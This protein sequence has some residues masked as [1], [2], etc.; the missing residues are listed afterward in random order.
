MAQQQIVHTE[1]KR[2]DLFSLTGRFDSS[3]AHE[4]SDAFEQAMRRGRF[5]FV[6]DLSKAEYI[7]SG[8]LRVLMA[9]QKQA[10]RFNRGD[11]YLAALPERLRE[12]L[13][14]AGLA[15]LFQIYDTPEDAVGAW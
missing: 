10:R 15:D 1:L 5:H 8:F 3:R 11:I 2:C 6:L 12:V 4:V 7:S 9:T 13:Q 14:L